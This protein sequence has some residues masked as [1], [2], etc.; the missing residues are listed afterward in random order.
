MFIWKVGMV[1]SEVVM[2]WRRSV[3]TRGRPLGASYL[4]LSKLFARFALRVP[5]HHRSG[6]K[7]YSPFKSALNW[8]N[9]NP[10]GPPT[11]CL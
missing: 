5:L 1:T 3:R 4:N 7:R 2:Y 11:F 9:R 10:S 8:Y 6:L